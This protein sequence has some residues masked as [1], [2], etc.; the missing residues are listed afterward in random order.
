VLNN[1]SQTLPDSV[2]LTRMEGVMNLVD[3]K[4]TSMITQVDGM[5]KDISKLQTD[6]HTLQL[7]AASRDIT[8]HSVA[9]ALTAADD[10]REHKAEQ[11]WGPVSKA[12]TIVVALGV[13][14]DIAVKLWI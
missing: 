12:V 8:A 5:K 1:D 11:A 9:D 13:L 3:Y 6:V 4:V 14:V 10:V 2:Q 7:E